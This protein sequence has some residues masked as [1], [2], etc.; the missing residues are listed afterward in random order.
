[1]NSIK[2]WGLNTRTISATSYSVN[3]FSNP[4]IKNEMKPGFEFSNK[5][6]LIPTFFQRHIG[7]DG[8]EEAYYDR[9]YHLHSSLTTLGEKYLFIDNGLDRRLDNRLIAEL[10]NC[11][12]RLEVQGRISASTI[13]ESIVLPHLAAYK[14]L[15]QKDLAAGKIQEIIEAYL[16]RHGQG[17]LYELKNILFHMLHWH[18]LYLPGLFKDYDYLDVSPKVLF[19]GDI[20]KREIYFLHFLYSMSIDVLHFHTERDCFLPDIDHENIMCQLVEYTRK[21][22]EKP[23]PREKSLSTIA[24]DAKKATEELRTTLHSDDSFFYKPWQFITYSLNSTIMRSTYEEIAIFAGEDAKMRTGWHAG[25][26]RVTLSNFFT[27]IKG[28]HSDENKYWKELNELIE[29]D[30]TLFINALPMLSPSTELKKKEYYAILDSN[31]IPDTTKLLTSEFWPYKK[32]PDHVQKFISSKMALLC[33]LKGIKRDTSLPV[34]IQK[35]KIFSLLLHIPEKFLQLLQQFDFPAK[36]PKIV[37]YNNE[38]NGDMTIEDAIVL[39]FMASSGIDVFVFNPSGH[40]D[41]ETYLDEKCYDKHYLE[42]IVFNLSYKSR[43]ILGR[44]F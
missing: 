37:V 19:Y 9:L 16:K 26:Q 23:F 24:T 21:L 44:F 22:E 1:M 40:N 41:I 8:D 29:H 28:T 25:Q 27:L 5:T 10:Q 32:Y 31:H 18:N 3:P 4:L 12:Q 42:K 38:K 11:W 13:T 14:D 2:K 43:S 15:L 39:Y 17:K 6:I 34:E 30:M 20:S 7:V 36:I 33:Q 35:I